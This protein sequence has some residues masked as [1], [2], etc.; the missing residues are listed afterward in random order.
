MLYSTAIFK[1]NYYATI[2]QRR[3]LFLQLLYTV[4]HLEA[5]PFTS[6]HSHQLAS[7]VTPPTMAPTTSAPT[8]Y[9]PGPAAFCARTGD[10]PRSAVELVLTKSAAS[11]FEKVVPSP[12][13]PLLM[14]LPVDGS[15]P[16]AARLASVKPF[17]LKN[18]SLVCATFAENELRV[19]F[20]PWMRRM[21]SSTG[22]ALGDHTAVCTVKGTG[23]V[24]DA[25]MRGP[26]R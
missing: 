23:R 12:V 18:C 3:T 8:G 4:G 13:V 21:P 10:A 14:A 15:V 24:S 22:R 17:W 20:A 25:Y 19:G 1:L 2:I 5:K 9:L 16:A 26:D 6:R 7:R 11:M